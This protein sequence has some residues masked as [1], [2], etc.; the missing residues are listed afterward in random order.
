MNVKGW[1]LIAKK[2][3]QSQTVDAPMKN[4]AASVKEVTVMATPACFIACGKCLFMCITF[5]LTW[6]HLSHFLFWIQGVIK[7]V[8][9]LNYHKHVVHTLNLIFHKLMRGHMK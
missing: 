8:H 3:L 7:I 9:A 5:V 6:T 1:E 4:A 2:I